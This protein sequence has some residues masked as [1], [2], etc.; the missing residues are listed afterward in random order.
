MSLYPPVFFLRRNKVE[1]NSPWQFCDFTMT[2]FHV[3]SFSNSE[4]II[5]D[6]SEL[7]AISLGETFVQDGSQQNE[8][9]NPWGFW[10]SEDR[11]SILAN[12]G[13]ITS[14]YLPFFL[15]LQDTIFD[16]PQVSA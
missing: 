5:C 15:V 3:R 10:E 11:K 4:L 2:P 12:Q 13:N 9:Q 6:S 1:R 14:I 8:Q 16:L 7:K